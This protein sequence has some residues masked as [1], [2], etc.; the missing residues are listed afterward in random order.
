[1]VSESPTPVIKE[2][3]VDIPESSGDN[4]EKVKFI[5]YLSIKQVL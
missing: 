3:E 1:M 4:S 2:T 5:H